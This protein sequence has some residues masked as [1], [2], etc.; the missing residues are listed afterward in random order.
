MIVQRIILNCISYLLLCCQIQYSSTVLLLLWSADRKSVRSFTTKATN[1]K[2]YS[3]MN[4]H[5]FKASFL[6]KKAV[7]ANLTTAPRLDLR[8]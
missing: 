5:G 1:L 2:Q 3:I 7:A 4:T 8:N 6:E